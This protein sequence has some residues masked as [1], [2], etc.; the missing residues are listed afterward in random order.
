MLLPADP[1]FVVNFPLG[2]IES[3]KAKIKSASTKLA[4]TE[5]QISQSASRNV[6]SAQSAQIKPRT[7]VVADEKRGGGSS[8]EGNQVGSQ[9]WYRLE[10]LRA[11]HCVLVED[12]QRS[13]SADVGKD[14]DPLR[15]ASLLT[16]ACWQLRDNGSSDAGNEQGTAAALELAAAVVAAGLTSGSSDF[17]R[18]MMDTL[19]WEARKMPHITC[20]M[21]RSV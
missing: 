19:R 14:D 21:E 1:L 3:L 16:A 9:A 20:H 18:R 6:R 8:D 17:S 15:Q 13:E 11:Q 5:R 2:K 12:L 7:N 4:Q 10:M